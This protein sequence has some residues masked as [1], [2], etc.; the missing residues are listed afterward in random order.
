MPYR[1]YIA[2]ITAFLARLSPHRRRQARKPIYHHDGRGSTP[3]TAGF[4]D[5]GVQIRYVPRDPPSG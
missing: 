4:F 2:A 1:R 5:D 3:G